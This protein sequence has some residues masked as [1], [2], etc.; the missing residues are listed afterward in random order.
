MAAIWPVLQHDGTASG[1]WGDERAALLLDIARLHQ[2]LQ[3]RD[4]SPAPS[5]RQNCGAS[6][7]T[8]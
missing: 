3:R 1:E 5:G 6:T 7:A 4:Q 2:E 8:S